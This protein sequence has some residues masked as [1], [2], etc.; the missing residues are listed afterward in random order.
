MTDAP[1][2]TVTTDRSESPW[3]TPKRWILAFVVPGLSLAVIAAVALALYVRE[4]TGGMSPWP[5]PC[6]DPRALVPAEVPSLGLELAVV[7]EAS[8]AGLWMPGHHAQGA[9]AVYVSGADTLAGVWALRYPDES[10]AKADFDWSEGWFDRYSGPGLFSNGSFRVPG[11]A[12]RRNE[13]RR[14]A[15]MTCLHRNWIVAVW[16][17]GGYGIP[18][19][20]LTLALRD[21]IT[22]HWRAG[23][24]PP[25]D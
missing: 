13:T 5:G 20:K 4:Y 25:G 15:E 23:A 21:A 19:G 9:M 22:E 2:T 17:N 6:A 3:R 1:T 8:A 10:Q 14:F 24:A 11:A 18:S 16:A 7:R 12:V